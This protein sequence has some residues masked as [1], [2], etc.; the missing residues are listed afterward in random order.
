MMSPQPHNNQGR[1][2]A[3]RRSVVCFRTTEAIG[4]ACKVNGVVVGWE[5]SALQVIVH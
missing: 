4:S 2:V 1:H 5:R 3:P